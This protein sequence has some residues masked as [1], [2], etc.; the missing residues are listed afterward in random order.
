VPIRTLF[1]AYRLFYG[2][3]L[4]F[5]ELSDDHLSMWKRSRDWRNYR[6]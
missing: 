3:K 4:N 2:Y 6:V 5:K 1:Y